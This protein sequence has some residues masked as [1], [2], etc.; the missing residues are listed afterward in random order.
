MI[1]GTRKENLTA[2]LTVRTHHILSGLSEKLGGLDEG[3]N[4]HEIFEASLA[5]CTILTVQMYANRKGI[6]LKSANVDVKITAEGA[7][8]VISREISFE[9]DLTEEE[10]KLL[11]SIAEKC[12]IHKLMESHIKIE[13]V[14]K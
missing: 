10:V 14:I 4:P 2:D 3:M 1:T 13:T 5:A 6:K 9:G 7:E 12:P 8:S 11:G